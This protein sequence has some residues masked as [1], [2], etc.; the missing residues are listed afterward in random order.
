MKQGFFLVPDLIVFIE[1]KSM[2]SSRLVIELQAL[3]PASAELVSIPAL[4]VKRT[5]SVHLPFGIT[6]LSNHNELNI[7][8]A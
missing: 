6:Y 3:S 8:A 5:L 4:K 1:S 2:P 7:S